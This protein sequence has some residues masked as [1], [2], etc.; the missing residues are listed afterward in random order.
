MRNGRNLAVPALC[1][2]WA[3]PALGYAMGC[4]M[5]CPDGTYV[6]DLDCDVELTYDPCASASGSGGSGYDAAAAWQAQEAARAA[7]EAAAEAERQRRAE[8]DRQYSEDQQHK[9]EQ[10]RQE[11]DRV[12]A[13]RDATIGQLK[14]G[15]GAAPALKGGPDDAGVGLKD[16]V[17]E[18]PASPA[19]AAQA[20]AWRQLHCAAYIA[21]Y[22]LDALQAGNDYKEFNALSSEALKAIDGQQPG[23]E[24]PAAPAMPRGGVPVARS[25]AAQAKERQILQRAA[26]IAQRMQQAGI[27][28]AAEPAK[29]SATP[30]AGETADEKMR[31]VQRE[32]N[33]VND[34]KLQGNTA[35][36]LAREERD[37]QE[38]ARLV[39]ENAKLTRVGFDT[40]EEAA[41][42]PRRKSSAPA[43]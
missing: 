25:E 38:L 5:L 32:L 39:L 27:A 8:L 35:A 28:P 24:C 12:R 18:R 30:P 20:A 15:A 17:A 40:S 21:R 3:L 22:A 6:H 29:A 4:S 16:A 36:E 1:A 14:G 41:P 42:V 13:N 34:R 31:R 9:Q 10:A 33:A 23:V 11:A 2:L 43:P 19:S 7:A 37:R 26:A